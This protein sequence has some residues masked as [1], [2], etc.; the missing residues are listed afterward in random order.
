LLSVATVHTAAADTHD[1]RQ[2]QSV[3]VVLSAA[4]QYCLDHDVS[5]AMTSGAAVTIA[6][7]NVTIDCNEHKIGGLAAGAGSHA[8]GI[9]A[10]NRL[11]TTI[12]HC[13]VRGFQGGISLDGAS[14][15]LVEDNR[16]D[17][18]LFTG[19]FIGAGD[20]NLIRRNQVYATGGGATTP[21]Y[22]IQASADVVDNIVSGVVPGA[23]DAYP[24]GISATG[25]G[26]R[27]T[28]NRVRG[29]VAAGSGSAQGIAVVAP[30]IVVRGNTVAAA[31]TTAGWGIHGHGATDTVCAHNVS[32]RFA[33]ATADCQDGGGNAS[34]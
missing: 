9:A 10:S 11:N 34:H 33:T 23:A 31:T 3:P 4:G 14:G 29:L 27:I 32:V 19:I 21:G 13:S 28:G 15:A 24:T 22:G 30:G 1:C 18:N 7:N 17:N 26:T 5:T 20:N 8:N 25:A 2:I 6:A 16:L 12:R